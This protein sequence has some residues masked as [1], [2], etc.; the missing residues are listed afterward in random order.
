MRNER[1]EEYLLLEEGT[2]QVGAAAQG[3]NGPHHEVLAAQ[4]HNEVVP[5][6]STHHGVPMVPSDEDEGA[7]EHRGMQA[8]ATDAWVKDAGFQVQMPFLPAGSVFTHLQS[9]V[10]SASLGP[11]VESEWGESSK[12]TLLFCEPPRTIYHLHGPC[13][14][15]QCSAKE[16]VSP[17]APTK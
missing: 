10:G 6:S 12:G 17:G 8:V 2:L 15:H 5:Y 9:G 13:H 11:G 4:A 14:S 16:A 1:A 3:A 7:Q